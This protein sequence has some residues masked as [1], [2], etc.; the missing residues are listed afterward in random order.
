ME[1]QS[2]GQRVATALEQ[3]F[4][5]CHEL[6]TRVLAR[7]E[8]QGSFETW[9]MNSLLGLMR[10]TAQI[11]GTINRIEGKSPQKNLEN[12]GSIPQENCG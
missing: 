3:E 8:K 12:R 7:F 4:Q 2:R 9:E 10:T 5:S 1:A 6:L 11:A